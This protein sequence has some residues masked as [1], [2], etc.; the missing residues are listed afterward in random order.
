MDLKEQLDQAKN[1]FFEHAEA[2]Y[3]LAWRDGR[4]SADQRPHRPSPAGVPGQR[5][6]A[7]GLV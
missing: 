4:A 6:G 5:M 1:P 7:V 2:Q 3:F